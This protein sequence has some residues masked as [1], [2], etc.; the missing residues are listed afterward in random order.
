[1]TRVNGADGTDARSLT[2]ARSKA[3]RRSTTSSPISSTMLP[4]F[5]KAYFTKTAPF[6]GIR[7]TRRIVGQYVMTQEDVLAC[8]HFD[9]SIAVASYPIDIHRPADEGCTLIW[10]G[11]CYD[12]PYRSLVPQK[13][14]QPAG[15]RSL[16]LR[17]ARG[18]GRH[19]RHG[20]LHGHGRSRRPRRQDLGA[21][22]PGARRNRCRGI[23]PPAARA[24]RLPAQRGRSPS[25]RL[26]DGSRR[27]PRTRPGRR[28]HDRSISSASTSAPAAPA[29]ASST[30][31]AHARHGQARHHALYQDGA[32]IAE[33][34]SDDIWQAVCACVREAVAAASRSRRT[35]S[36]ASASTR[37][38]RWS[39]SGEGGAPLPVGPHRR[40]RPQHH[41]LDGPPRDRAGASASTRTRHT[42]LDYVGGRSRRRWRRRSCCG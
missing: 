22:Q 23:A 33:Q 39:C 28:A 34:S 35:P 9:D 42:V 36:P 17:H 38:A 14:R 12:I 25:W 13:G 30:R 3:A 1:M 20:D 2:E 29:P 6:L 18:D 15:R 11:D 5:E 37:P 24:R 41:R 26:E 27:P 32:D 7:E 19:P 4:G 16:H 31:R 8:R 10:C 40:S 21:R